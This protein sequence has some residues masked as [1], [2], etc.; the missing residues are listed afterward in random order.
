MVFLIRPTTKV[1]IAPATHATYRLSDNGPDIDIVSSPGK[2]R[3][4]FRLPRASNLGRI[5]KHC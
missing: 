3:A 4:I 1:T 2:R 5:G